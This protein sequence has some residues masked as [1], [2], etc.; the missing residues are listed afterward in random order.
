MS[1]IYT[2]EY[3]KN[4]TLYTTAFFVVLILIIFLSSHK[5]FAQEEEIYTLKASDYNNFLAVNNGN[6]IDQT[7]EIYSLSGEVGP[8]YISTQKDFKN[9][10]LISVYE[11]KDGDT[12]ESIAKLY[13]INKNTIVWAN[14]LQGKTLKNG[15]ILIILPI[16][17]IKYNIRKGDN[18]ESL[19]KK[20][21]V[22]AVDIYDYNN[23]KDNRE[24]ILGNEIFIPNAVIETVKVA[25]NTKSVKKSNVKEKKITKSANGYFVR[26]IVGGIKTQGIHGHNA[27]DI[28]VSIGTPIRAS[29]SGVVVVA[30][31]DGYNGGYGGLIII[32]HDNGTQTV[33][34]HLSVVNVS[35][36]QS[37]DQGQNIGLSGNTGKSTGPHLHFE[38]RGATNPF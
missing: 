34:G 20:Y 11:V 7:D 16:D 21:K 37:V 18:I 12:V 26:P 38:I 32:K 19:A 5:A 22:D 6:K 23:I 30:K 2:K 13:N 15:Q 28:G 36:G 35:S 33:Y 4:N 8:L 10:D 1:N 17:G 31:E 29:A 14:D 27:I 24:L 3:Q 25:E 9:Q